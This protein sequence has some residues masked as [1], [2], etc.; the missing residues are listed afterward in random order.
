M[1]KR[2]QVNITLD[3]TEMHNVNEYC[4]VHNMTPQAFFRSGGKKMISEDLLERN[5]D[6]MTLQSLE[7]IESGLDTPIDDLL[8]MIE[9]DL[10]ATEKSATGPDGKA[11]GV[12]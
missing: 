3:D 5:A 9:E 1:S 7:E 8:Q 10:N 6:L 11:K 4:R 2:N 12:Q